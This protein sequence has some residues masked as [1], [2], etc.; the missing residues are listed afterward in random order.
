MRYLLARGARALLTV[1][2][3]TTLVFLM[4]HVIPG[5]PVDAILGDQATP[6]DRAALRASLRLDEPLLTQYGLFLNDIQNGSL[7]RSFHHGQQQVR[8]L[9]SAALPYTAEL[10]VASLLLALALALPMGVLA[11][12]R[13]GRASDRAAT[14]LASLGIAIPNIWLGPMLVLLFGVG[15]RWLPLP[16]DEQVGGVA[17][18]LPAITVG[19]ALAAVLMRQTRTGLIEVLSAPYIRAARARGLSNAAVLWKHALR[20]ALLPVLTVA[21]AQLGALLSGAVITERIFERPGLGNLFLEAFFNRD[22]PLVQGCVL[23]TALIYVTVNLLIDLLYGV[24][25]PR[26]RLS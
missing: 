17:L 23:V 18:I 2:G 20:N 14:A 1:W 10:S 4:V 26:V 6:E 25:D 16:G 12:M 3:V 21:G 24:I 22:L 8:E 9:I 15:L 19:T 13:H 7:G 11:A 5:D